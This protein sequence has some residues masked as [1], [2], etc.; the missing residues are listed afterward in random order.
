MFEK[1]NKLIAD[2]TAESNR[3]RDPENYHNIGKRTYS[4]RGKEYEFKPIY[5]GFIP[6]LSDTITVD[7]IVKPR[8]KLTLQQIQFYQ[9]K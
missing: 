8:E 7:G 2:I 4:Y 6:Q 5:D 1:Y 9:N 3:V